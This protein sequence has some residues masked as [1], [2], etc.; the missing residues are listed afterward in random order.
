MESTGPEV[1]GQHVEVEAKAATVEALEEQIKQVKQVLDVVS[2]VAAW[3]DDLDSHI[4]AC[5]A[6]VPDEVRNAV[7]NLRNVVAGDVENEVR[8][9]L[10]SLETEPGELE[11]TPRRPSRRIRIFSSAE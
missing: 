1:A 10:L 5:E 3:V 4:N 11:E 6:D 9:R 8:F 2:T 7:E